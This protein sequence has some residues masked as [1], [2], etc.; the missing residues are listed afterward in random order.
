MKAPLEYLRKT[1]MIPFF[2]INLDRSPDRLRWI[3]QR[4]SEL[5]IALSRV[6]A[7]DGRS[8]SSDEVQRWTNVV[9]SRFGMGPNEIACFLSHRKIWQ[10]IVSDQ[11]PW[12]FIAEDD[13]YMSNDLKRFLDDSQWIPPH[14]DLVKAETVKQRV[15][16][17]AQSSCEY[18]A[19][20]LVELRSFHGGSAGYFVSLACANKLLESTANF[21]VPLDQ[22]LFNQDFPP[23]QP[24]KIYQV[25][26]AL[27]AQD[28]VV[29]IP[30]AKP[31]FESLLLG[32]RNQFHGKKQP[33]AKSLAGL[34]WYK[35]TNPIKKVSKRSLETAANLL[36]THRVTKVAFDSE[37]RQAAA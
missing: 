6:S 5:G 14:A 25:L 35:V 4:T 26:P 3:Q 13:I 27:V 31:K 1:T 7:V 2:L 21:C 19:H 28:W 32:E 33:K 15:W 23:A 37:M 30:N 34:A 20:S 10:M 11:V 24:L 8:L 9:H 16:L 36:G 12:S 17:A 29:N 22:V 18:L